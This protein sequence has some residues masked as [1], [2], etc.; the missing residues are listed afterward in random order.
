VIL[1]TLTAPLA[2]NADENGNVVS[3]SC[4]KM[5]LGEPDS[6]GRRRPV[7]V[8][9]SEHEIECD[10]VIMAVGTAPNPLLR[11]TTPGLEADK[12]GCLIVRGDSSSTTREG[13]YAG[14]DAVSGAATV[15]LAMGA[16]R[17][18]A[19]EIDEYIKNKNN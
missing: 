3:L 18:A 4:Q 15:I 7:P 17:N 2:V 8:D 11:M 5:E 14:G 19:R 12:H 16:G 13:V 9:G 1:R 6:S 10:T